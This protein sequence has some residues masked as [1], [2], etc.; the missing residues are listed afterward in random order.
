MNI[1]IVGNGFDLSHYLPTKY[2]HFMDVM[3]AIETHE[4]ETISFDELFSKCRE[5]WFIAKTK[6]Y[7]LAENLSLEKDQLTEIKK[8][9][10]E[11]SWYQYFKDH[12]NEVKTW[13]D[14]EQKIEQVLIVSGRCIADIENIY[15]SEELYKYFDDDNDIKIRTTDRNILN[16]FNFSSDEFYDYA[17]NAFY[18]EENMGAKRTNINADYC[19]GRKIKNG[20]NSSLFLDFIQVQLE[21]FIKIFNLYLDLIIDKLK[22]RAKFEI[23]VQSNSLLEPERNCWIQPD[24]IYSFNYTNTYQRIHSQVKVE[25]LHGSH[26]EQQNIVLGVSDL[27]DKLLKKIKAYGFTKYH[28]KLFKETDYLFLDKYKE[29][30]KTHKRRVDYFEQDFGN[31]DPTAKKLE[32]QNIMEVESK[33]N[34]NISIW[35]HSLDVSDRDYILDLFSLNDDMDRNV[36]VIV[37]Y[38]DKPA[39]FSLLN[40]LLAILDKDKVEQWMKKGWLKFKPNPEINFQTEERAVLEEVS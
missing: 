19:N 6:E 17:I 32:R 30:V 8:L 40:N 15:N 12:V 26:G 31:T 4:G 14:F 39:K 1:L 13:I 20:F 2:D 23:F 7:Y 5:D 33:L 36:R 16:F 10:K 25:Y 29:K 27:E 3:G 28:Q 24:L 9:L 22:H 34:I 11:N 18:G 35:G 38:F 37:Y 21:D